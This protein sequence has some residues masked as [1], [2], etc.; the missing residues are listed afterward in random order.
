M[1]ILDDLAAFRIDAQDPAQVAGAIAVLVAA[2]SGRLALVREWENATARA[3]PQ[4]LVAQ[5][6]AGGR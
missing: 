6:T 2:P 5:L 4:T 3:M 1:A